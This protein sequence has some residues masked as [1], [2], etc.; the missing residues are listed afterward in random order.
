MFL[1]H[2]DS[3]GDLVVGR[4]LKGQG[5]GDK[6]QGLGY[7]VRIWR[8]RSGSREQGESLAYRVRV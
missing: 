3:P 8:T 2:P 4:Q 5:L 1:P 6:G 7:R